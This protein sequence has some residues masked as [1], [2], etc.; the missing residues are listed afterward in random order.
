[1]RITFVFLVVLG[2]FVCGA[3]Q[4]GA[5]Y[6]IYP[7]SFYDT[8]G[9]GIGDIKGIIQKLPYLDSLGVETLWLSP[10]F[11]HGGKD[12]GYDITD[13]YQISPEYGTIDDL[14]NLI[15]A[16]HARKM[17]VLLD[18]VMNHTSDA[19][20]WFQES[21]VSRMSGKRGWYVWKDGRK[22]NQKAPANWK[23]MLGG[24]GWQYD[25]TAQSW[26]WAS[27][28][29]FQ[30]DIN[31]RNPQA[32]K[33]MLDVF[34]YWLKFGADGYRLDIFNAIFEGNTTR[35]QP[36][37]L[38]PFPSEENPNGYFQKTIFTLNRPESVQFAQ[39]IR[40]IC[41][42]YDPPRTLLGEV[43]GPWETLR[44][45][46][47][48]KN[49]GLNYVFAFQTLKIQPRARYLRKL[50]AKQEQ[51]FAAPLTPVYVFSNHDRL[52]G[53][54]RW[55][56]SVAKARLMAAFQ[57]TVRGLPVMY[58]GDEWGVESGELPLKNAKDPLANYR[59]VPKWVTKKLRK[60]GVT[61]NRDDSRQPAP[62]TAS[63]GFSASDSAWLPYPPNAQTANAETQNADSSSILWT[64]RKLLALRKAYPALNAGELRLLK[65]KRPKKILCYT[66]SHENQTV[67]V[68]LNASNR[69][70]KL[71]LPA[72]KILY[73]THAVRR[74]KNKIL[75]APYQA[76]CGLL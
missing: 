10:V 59:K 60:R 46:C 69:K 63:G 61:L 44:E 66:R 37:S 15:H 67:L 32:Q 74:K 9:D 47:G 54:T 21:R 26:Y 36:F 31:Y 55:G 4:N 40:Q 35:N 43:F 42:E 52:R 20:S 72:T 27:F 33:A 16:A 6:Q 13:Y 56:G 65:T 57:M 50:I 11:C 41:N 48:E 12:G 58:Y 62:W 75:L 39:Q 29:P 76:V 17:R 68:V 64:Y 8:N 1:M 14:K 34:N 28:L 71:R 3:A 5:V 22:K 18:M 38:R 24:P 73:S 2:A 19:H 23:N 25:S 7:R 70:V 51:Y 53:F 49:D 45:Y 30:P